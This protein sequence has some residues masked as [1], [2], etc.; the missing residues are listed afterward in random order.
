[1]HSYETVTKKPQG[2]L[3]Q[4]RTRLLKAARSSLPLLSLAACMCLNAVLEMT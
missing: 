4:A 3:L 2:Q 1:M